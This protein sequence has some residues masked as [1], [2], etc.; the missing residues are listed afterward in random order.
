MSAPCGSTENNTFLNTSNQTKSVSVYFLFVSCASQH[1]FK[2]TPTVIVFR[3]F[4]Q[5]Q[6]VSIPVNTMDFDLLFIFVSVQLHRIYTY[7]RIYTP[8]SYSDQPDAEFPPAVRA[9]GPLFLSFGRRSDFV[10]SE[11]FSPSKQSL[12]NQLFWVLVNGVVALG[13]DSLAD[14]TR[15]EGQGRLVSCQIEPGAL[16]L[17]TLKINKDFFCFL[18][19]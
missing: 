10:V 14:E 17:F 1:P 2:D 19:Q 6:N 3:W 5:H 4:R 9:A 13:W 7:R 12:W 16:L 15:W 11:G 18:I 8:A